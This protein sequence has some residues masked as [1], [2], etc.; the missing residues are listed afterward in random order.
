MTVHLAQFNVARLTAAQNDPRVAD[1]M[2]TL[3]A[4]N[5]LGEAHP[6]FVWRYQDDSGSAVDT[7]VFDDLRVILNYTIWKSVEALRSYVYSGGH[8]E[9]FQRRREWFE[10]SSEPSLVMWWVPEGTI[11]D[12]DES[13]GR[14]AHLRANGLNAVAFGFAQAIGMEPTWVPLPAMS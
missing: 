3:D 13:Q 7:D 12:L 10:T 11:P 14:L 6:G 8:L 5:A 2:N 1:F 9:Y 4:I